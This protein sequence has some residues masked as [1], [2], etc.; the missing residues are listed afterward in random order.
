LSAGASEEQSGKNVA[1]QS[2][3]FRLDLH[4]PEPRFQ[5]TVELLLLRRP[6]QPYSQ[7]TGS[8]LAIEHP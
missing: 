6:Q 7:T 5:E 2:A 1:L 4:I 3:A 8:G